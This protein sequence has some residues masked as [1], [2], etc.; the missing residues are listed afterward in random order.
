MVTTVYLIQSAHTDI[1]FTHPQ[2]QI[3]LAYVDFYERVLALCAASANAR[4]PT[5][6]KWTCETAWQVQTF[7]AARPER[8]AELVEYVRNGQIE[9]T[10][11]YLHFTDLIDADALQR[12]FAWIVAFCQRHALPLRCAMHCDINGWPWALADQLAGL[13]VR[14]FYSAVHLD[15]STD[16]LGAR[17]SVHYQWLLERATMLRRDAPTRHPQAFWWQGPQGGTVLHWLGEHY[18]LGNALGL[19]GQAPFPAITTRHYYESD[20]D[21]VATLYATACRELPRYL[22]HLR[23]NGYQSDTVLIHTS[24]FYVDNSPPDDRW[25]RLVERWN[26]DHDSIKLR[27]ATLSEWFETL[28][29]TD[30][31]TYRVAWPDAWAFGL[32]SCTA[33][34]AENRR[35]QRR[36]RALATLATLVPR[37]VPMFEEAVQQERFALEHTFSANSACAQPAPLKNM[38]IENGKARNTLLASLYFD[39]AAAI[40]L[41]TLPT[42]AARPA[43]LMPP[44]SGAAGLATLHFSAGDLVLNPA[45]EL[46]QTADGHLYPFQNEQAGLPE[47]VAV[48][49]FTSELTGLSRVPA[50]HAATA[51]AGPP[52]LELRNAAWHLQLDSATGALASLCDASGHEWVDQGSSQR[53]GQLIHETIVHPWGRAAVGNVPRCI[54]LGSASDSARAAFPDQPIF[55]RRVAEI[56]TAPHFQAG[57]VFDALE[58]TANLGTAGQLQV[59]WRC[60][61]TLPLVELV[62]EW[63]KCWCEL[64]EAAYVTFPFAAPTAQLH[65]DTSGGLFTPGSHTDGGQLPGTAST[66]Y[67]VQRGALIE[68]ETARLVWLPLDA[69]LVVPN[70]IDFNRWETVPWRW[71]GLLASMP[72]NHYWHTNFPP[73]QRG[74]LRLRYRLGYSALAANRDAAWETAMPHDAFGWQW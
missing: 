28:D 60:Y 74:R 30:L 34:I 37:A 9:L 20:R 29:T 7:L 66:F 39:E 12:S 55:A 59:I 17:G 10:A 41:R 27:T 49:P 45:T 47:Y 5:R 15:T 40:A 44:T 8:E 71:N 67:T 70:S 63:D 1:G 21:D 38:L 73:S 69:P 65:F 14:Y 23:T 13:G 62:L 43:L 32:G 35:N 54:A 4:L 53:F 57:P 6:F 18:H 31:P 36:R 24:G 52:T 25:C 64:P 51:A 33:L 11:S 56:S 48:V 58:L 16:P 19:S 26:A 2:E 72:V 50:D 3:A 42:S 22:T 46:L 68:S 61:H